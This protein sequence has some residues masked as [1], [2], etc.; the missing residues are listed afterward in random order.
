MHP[1]APASR[2]DVMRFLFFVQ[3]GAVPVIMAPL[4]R[5]IAGRARDSPTAEILAIHCQHVE[6]AQLH[7][8]IVL[9]GVQC[10]KIGDAVDAKDDGLA[11]DHEVRLVLFFS[12]A[13]TIHGKRF[14]Q[15]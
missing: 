2:F 13:S 15:S 10:V 14:V 4:R 11:I 5:S 6:G 3:E 12:A 9:A 8:L 1:V 7:F